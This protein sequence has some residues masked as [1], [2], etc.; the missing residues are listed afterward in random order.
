MGQLGAQKGKSCCW[1][2]AYVRPAIVAGV[3]EKHLRQLE[4]TDDLRR[5]RESAGWARHDTLTMSAFAVVSCWEEDQE[6]KVYNPTVPYEN[7]G[8]LYFVKAWH[9]NS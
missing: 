1:L 9:C 5:E 7:V 8:V 3:A 4:C 6:G 2:T